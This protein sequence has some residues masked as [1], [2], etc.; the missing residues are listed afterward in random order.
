MAETSYKNI[1]FS[2]RRQVIVKQTLDSFSAGRE[3]LCTKNHENPSF[4]DF[5]QNCKIFMCKSSEMILL[6]MVL[7]LLGLGENL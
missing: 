5:R 3:I 7:K 6:L 2:F 4:D 1:Y